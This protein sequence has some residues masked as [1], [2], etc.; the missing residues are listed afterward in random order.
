VI[1]DTTKQCA[2]C[3]SPIVSGQRW[4]RKKIYD[5]GLGG[6]DPSYHRYHAE[7]FPGRKEA[8]GKSTKWKW[9]LVEPS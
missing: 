9:K 7:P 6:R 5:P 1:V 8:V 4:V 3:R 2:Y